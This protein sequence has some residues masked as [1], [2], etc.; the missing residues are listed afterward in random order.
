MCEKE[1]VYPS[2]LSREE[3]A[4]IL[5]LL[6]SARKKTAPREVYLY[7]VFNALLYVLPEG[8]RWR[9]LPQKYP[10]W[11]LVYY[12]FGIWKESKEGESSIL[13]QVLKK[14]LGKSAQLQGAKRKPVSS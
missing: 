3:F 11:E 6:E 2:E 7:D 12:Y 1:E 8:C 10:K 4:L 9:S 13:E 14:W 5:P